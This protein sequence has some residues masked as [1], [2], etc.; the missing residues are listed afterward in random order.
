[1]SVNLLKY[2]VN[3]PQIFEMLDMVETIL[4]S[5]VHDTLMLLDKR[6]KEGGE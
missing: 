4:I 5:Q 6:R 3:Y 2:K 1:M